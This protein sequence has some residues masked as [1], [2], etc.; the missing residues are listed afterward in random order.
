MIYI[1]NSLQEGVMTDIYRTI[2][3]AISTTLR[4]NNCTF[5]AAFTAV[6]QNYKH[7]DWATTRSKVGSLLGSRKKRKPRKIKMPKQLDLLFGRPREEVLA[8]AAEQEANLTR[9]IPAHDL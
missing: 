4:Q 3:D 6:M 1:V 5:N 8:D 2:A 9:G 7:L